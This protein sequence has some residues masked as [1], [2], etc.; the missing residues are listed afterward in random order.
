MSDHSSSWIA[1]TPP[2]E[3]P[4]VLRDAVAYLA[5]AHDTK[6]AALIDGL[7]AEVQRLRQAATAEPG[8]TDRR[9]ANT[10]WLLTRGGPE[11]TDTTAVFALLRDVADAEPL[12]MRGL[13]HDLSRQCAM[14]GARAVNSEP[15]EHHLS[16]P[17]ARVTHLVG[18]KTDV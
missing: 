2:P 10:E 15:V 11:L 16:C 7:A 6:A 5:T 17:W 9:D 1:G 3:P 12:I 13:G 8:T 4:D 18:V 14:C